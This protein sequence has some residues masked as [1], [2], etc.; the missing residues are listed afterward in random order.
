MITIF[1]LIAVV[2]IMIAI[3]LKED[4]VI[5]EY[6]A[7]VDIDEYGN[8][9]VEETYVIDYNGLSETVSKIVDKEVKITDARGSFSRNLLSLAKENSTEAIKISLCSPLW[10]S[11]ALLKFL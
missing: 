10:Y 4:I 1:I 5:E 7:I 8:M 3:G 9:T 6:I 11:K 2:V